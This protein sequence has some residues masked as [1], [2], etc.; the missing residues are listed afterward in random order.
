MK[1]LI[2]KIEKYGFQCEAGPLSTCRDWIA[3]KDAITIERDALAARVAGVGLT[4]EDIIELRDWN[5]TREDVTMSGR[6]NGACALAL[7]A[8]SARAKEGK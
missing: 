7:A 8:L 4:A 2:E 1:D 5:N 6:V 3:L